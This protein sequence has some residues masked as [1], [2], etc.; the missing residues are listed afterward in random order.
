[1]TGPPL[2]AARPVS[3]QGAESCISRLDQAVVRYADRPALGPLTL[4][5]APG[6]IVALVGASGA[7]KSTALRLLAGLEAPAEGSVQRP[8]QPNATG[9]V[10]Q[11]PTLMPW[12]D[13]RTNVALP[14]ELSG[15]PAAEARHRADLALAAVGLGDRTTARPRQLSGGMAM[16]VS[17]A[18]ALSIRPELLLLDEPFA[19]LDSITRRGLIEDL[20]RL[21]AERPLA[22]VFVTHDVEEAAYLAGRVVVLSAA[23]GRAVADVPMPGPL[24]RPE[25][26]RRDPAFRDAVEAVASGLSHAMP[27]AA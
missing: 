5:V 19:A 8:A 7:G 21:W 2:A 26:W 3:A 20:H 15:V 23:D 22:M 14:L 13:A 25:G 24:P 12:A 16:R 6:E 11:S 18:R 17:L 27:V 9:F 4:A 10:F 1:M